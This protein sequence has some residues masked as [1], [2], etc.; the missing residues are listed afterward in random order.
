[1]ITH[2]AGQHMDH[3]NYVH[4]VHLSHHEQHDGKEPVTRQTSAFT[5]A[6]GKNIQNSRKMK[7]VMNGWHGNGC[8]SVAQ[9]QKGSLS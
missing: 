7:N 1:M 5:A 8:N 2:H 6:A 3:M 4:L 9:V